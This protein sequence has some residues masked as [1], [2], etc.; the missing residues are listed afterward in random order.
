MQADC[1][2]LSLI[3]LAGPMRSGMS[4]H[5]DSGN[6]QEFLYTRVLLFT[7]IGTTEILAC[8]AVV[9]FSPPHPP[10]PFFANGNE[11]VVREQKAL[12]H[13]ERMQD[14]SEMIPLTYPLK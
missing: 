4:S 3:Q 7:G 6:T 14:F 9:H 1:Q 5:Y 13:Q 2:S 11:H 10:P 12:T 8:G